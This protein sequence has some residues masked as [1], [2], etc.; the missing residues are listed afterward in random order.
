MRHVCWVV[1]IKNLYSCHN[2]FRYIKI[3]DEISNTNNTFVFMKEQLMGS[4]FWQYVLVGFKHTFL[5]RHPSRLFTSYR[6][7]IMAMFA[8]KLPPNFDLV[9]DDFLQTSPME[10]YG[11]LLKFW[12]YIVENI[13][14]NP[15]I[16]DTED[17]LSKPGPT[18]QAYCEAVG[19][20]YSDDLL[21]WEATPDLPKNME[22]GSREIY[23]SLVHFYSRALNS[24]HFMPNQ[25]P[26][27]IPRDQLSDDV[28]R[29]VDH[30]MP[31]YVEMSKHKLVIPD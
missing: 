6:K 21:Q 12:R 26:G 7:A 24:T 17:L 11:N 3:K 31:V 19:F 14:P 8:E 23:K 29:C 10:W 13:D 20:P 1:L 30:A 4:S 16:I 27:P 28:I 5:I 15:V 18:L 22:A 25:E 9:R 2:Y